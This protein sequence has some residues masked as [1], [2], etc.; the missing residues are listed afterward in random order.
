MTVMLK[1]ENCSMLEERKFLIHTDEYSIGEDGLID[2][3]IPLTDV[4]YKLALQLQQLKTE[5]E[6][7]KKSKQA[8]YEAMQIEWNKAINELRDLKA[9]DNIEFKQKLE[10]KLR[11][12]NEY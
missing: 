11:S 12:S 2:S 1:R 5:F 4:C 6:Q 3:T 7:Y 8:S 10:Q 9:T